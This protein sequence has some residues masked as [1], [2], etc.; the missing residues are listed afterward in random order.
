MPTDFDQYVDEEVAVMNAE[1]N[2]QEAD[3]E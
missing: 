3:H 1:Q 2:E